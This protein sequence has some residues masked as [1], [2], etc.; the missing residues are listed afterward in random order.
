MNVLVI[1]GSGFLGSHTADVLTEEGYNV[2][3]FD[4]V[5]SP[6][7][8]KGQKMIKG[9]ILDKKAVEKAVKGCDIV[10]NFAG[11]TD[12]EEAHFKP[13]ETIEGNIVGNTI[14][15]EACRKNNVKR[16]IFKVL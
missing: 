14:V 7:L 6:Y 10:Y 4:I 8:Q 15:L 12:I 9:S 1:G 13:L 16:F 2:K 5:D 11:M 3:I